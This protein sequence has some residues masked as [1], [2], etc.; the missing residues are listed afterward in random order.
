M[1][2]GAV[3]YTGLRNLIPRDTKT[4]IDGPQNVR[5]ISEVWHGSEWRR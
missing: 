1:E 5:K 3:L 2:S 4:A